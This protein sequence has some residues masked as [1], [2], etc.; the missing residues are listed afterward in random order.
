MVHGAVDPKAS[1]PDLPPGYGIENAIGPP[2][3]RLPWSQVSEWLATARNYWVCTSR[4]DGRPHT[5]PVWGL[6]LDGGFIFSTHPETVT[7]RNLLAS[8]AVTVHLESGDQVLILEGTAR[9]THDRSFL[10]R[11]GRI[12]GT[13]YRWPVSPDDVDPQNPNA[14][15]YWVQPRTAV[16]WRTATEIGETITRWTFM[17]VDR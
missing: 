5:K 3:E 17:D 12:Y 4:P 8:S 10:T 1:R 14:A 2:G 11:F 9:R 15:F 7:A 13:K 6:W 16:S